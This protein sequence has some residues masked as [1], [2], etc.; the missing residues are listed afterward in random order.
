[1][2]FSLLDF[3]QNSTIFEPLYAK[4]RNDPESKQKKTRRWTRKIS[5]RKTI[6]VEKSKRKKTQKRQLTGKIL[7]RCH[8]SFVAIATLLWKFLNNYK[9]CD[10][11]AVSVSCQST[12]SF[13]FFLLNLSTFIVFRLVTLLMLHATH[14]KLSSVLISL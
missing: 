10:A 12:A 7:G 2:Q 1:M 9:G 6:S 5:G 14:C 4:V 8:T 13:F 3:N 11:G